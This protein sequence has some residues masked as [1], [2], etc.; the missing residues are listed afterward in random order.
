MSYLSCFGAFLFLAVLVGL[1]RTGGAHKYLLLA[2][3]VATVIWSGVVVAV[4]WIG[5]FPK[6]LAAAE[7]LRN[8]LWLTML[9]TLLGIR[10]FEKSGLTAR[11]AV[12]TVVGVSLILLYA[13]SFAEKF[14]PPPSILANLQTI[15]GGG[16]V[17][18]A[19]IGLLAIENLYRNSS[20]KLRWA[21]KYFC[22]GLG[23]ILVYDFVLYADGVLFGQLDQEF[24]NVRGF[25]NAIIVPLLAISVSRAA[26]WDIDIHISRTA[27]FHTTALIGSGVYLIGMAGIGFYVREIGGEWGRVVQNLL[28]A[29]TVLI[30]IIIFSSAAMRAKFKV[31]ISKHFFSYKYDYREE[32]LRFIRTITS[33]EGPAGLHERIVRSVGDIV[34][35]SSGGLWVLRDGDNAFL[36]TVTMQLGDRPPAQSLDSPLVRFLSDTHWIVDLEEYRRNPARYGDVEIPAWLLETRSVWLIVPLIYRDSM[37]AFLVLGRP[38]ASRELGWEDYDLLRTVGN[39][40]ASYLAEEQAMNELSDARRLDDFN[41]RSAFIIHDIKNVVSQMSLLVQNAEKFGDNPEFQKDMIATVGNS[42]TRM[43]DLLERFKTVQQPISKT[44]TEDGP[45]SDLAP[46]MKI[47]HDVAANWCKQKPDLLVDLPDTIGLLVDHSRLTSVLDHLL[48]NAIE[49]AGVSGSVALRQRV[50][51]REVFI[52]VE[53]DG[54]GMDSGYIENRLFRPLDSQKSSGFGLGAYQTRQLVREMGGR[55]E[56]ISE[57]GH[58]TVMRVVLPLKEGLG[59]A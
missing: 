3:C 55:L 26:L 39:Q 47:V 11:L 4:P 24:F 14:P 43:K 33:T 21:I 18:L 22:F 8:L 35:C 58:G 12:M 56:V 36:P 45:A 13:E 52:E 50:H 17:F 2:C 5:P 37:Q 29:T 20:V 34:D 57:V 27:V 1:S 25:A 31:W 42:V 15:V 46:L 19:A 6:I 51:G 30:L 7:I 49:A 38:R 23:T 40:A 48:Q 16:H 44:M 9:G 54:P 59:V 53:D 10:R 41:R 28:L 32:W